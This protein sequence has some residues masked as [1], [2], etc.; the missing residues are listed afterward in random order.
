MP[1]GCFSSANLH[2]E[3]F[4]RS[5]DKEIDAWQFSNGYNDWAEGLMRILLLLNGL[6]ERYVGDADTARQRMWNAYCTPGT[7]LEVGYLPSIQENG[8]GAKVYEFGTKDALT[9]GLLYPDRC[10]FLT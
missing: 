6:R 3:E 7:D 5:R 9:L 4:I 1:T 10:A 2:Q 8:S